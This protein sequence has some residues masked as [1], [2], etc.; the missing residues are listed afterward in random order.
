MRRRIGMWVL[1]AGAALAVLLAVL[2]LC[3]GPALAATTLTGPIYVKKINGT[4][5]WRDGGWPDETDESVGQIKQI[6]DLYHQGYRG[7]IYVASGDYEV[8]ETDP[9]QGVNAALWLLP[10]L[11]VYGGFA[12]TESRPDQRALDAHGRPV[13]Q[14]VLRPGTYA[15]A[16]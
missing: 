16:P 12:G 4:I 6:P 11:R 2:A 5:Y 1:R 10:G 9:T 8:A 15:G 13:Y 7:D 3:A 14:T